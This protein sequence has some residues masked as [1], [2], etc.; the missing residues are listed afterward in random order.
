MPLTDINLY[1]DPWYFSY[2]TYLTPLWNLIAVS[3]GAYFF[4]GEL[5]KYS[6]SPKKK[7]IL[8]LFVY[9]I[10][11]L[12]IG[13]LTS[14]LIVH[15]P[16]KFYHAYRIKNSRFM[17]QPYLT[18]TT[19]D[20]IRHDPEQKIPWRDIEAIGYI[21]GGKG[22][23]IIGIQIQL[24]N[25]DI[26]GFDRSFTQ[27]TPEVLNLMNHYLTHSRQASSTPASQPA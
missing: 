17:T 14:I 5:I 1:L 7:F 21:R 25:G 26:I 6:R 23:R 16:K 11:V 18:L 8:S 4:I 9:P 2:W 24:K 22:K 19:A 12:F 13:L 10:G 3:F 15:V 27:S 20:F